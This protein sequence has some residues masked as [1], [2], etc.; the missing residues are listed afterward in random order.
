MSF[1]AQKTG[2]AGDDLRVSLGQF[3]VNNADAI[4]MNLSFAGNV[5]VFTNGESNTQC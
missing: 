1:P 2:V 3:T 5:Q 4:N